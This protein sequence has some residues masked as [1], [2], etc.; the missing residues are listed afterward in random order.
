[1]IA[2]WGKR[3]SRL[4]TMSWDEVSTRARQ[5]INKRLEL[6]AYRTGRLPL[7]KS[8]RHPAEGRAKFFFSAG[9]LPEIADLLRQSS[10]VQVS[11]I[12]READ[13]ICAH[14][15]HL[16]GYDAL[17]YG[18][19]IDWH[20]DAVHGKRAPLKPWFKIEFLDFAEVGD[21]KVTW[22]LNRHQH[23][24]TLAKAWHFAD[25]ERREKYVREIVAQWDSWQRA[26]PYP[27]G[28]NWGSSLEVAFRS[29]SWIWVDQLL[30]N[31]DCLAAE[32]RAGLADGL[33]LNGRYVERYLSTY[34][35][36]NTHLLGEAV[37]LF[38]IGTLYPQIPSA[39]RWQKKGWQIVVE[40]A[41]RQVR[42]DGVY[43]EQA[44]YY[45]V[46]ALDFFLHLRR[47]ASLN[48]FESPA[49]FDGVLAKMGEVLMVLSQAGPP[50]GFGDDDG[51]RLFNPR[52]NRPEHLADPLALCALT[53]ERQDFLRAAPLTEEAVWLF[54]KRV[55]DLRTGPE[56]VHAELTTRAFADGGL[57]VMADGESGSQ[58]ILDAGP[59][60][61]GH[62][63]HGHADALSVNMSV[64][65]RP[66]LVDS[67]SYCYISND[68]Q[69]SAFR[70][71]AAH[72]TLRVDGL[73]QAVLDGPF[74]WKSIPM[75]RVERWIEGASFSLFVGSHDGYER[76]AAPVIHR[77]F[78][79]HLHG[80]FWLVR[81][82]ALGRGA[83]QLE[84]FWH[85]APQVMVSRVEGGFISG[86]EFSASE[87]GAGP[88]S[89]LALLAPTNQQWSAEANTGYV[90]HAY[91]SKQRAPLVRVSALSQLPAEAVALLV[92]LHAVETPGRFFELQDAAKNGIKGFQYD[93]GGIVQYLFFARAG[94]RWRV[95]PWSSNARILFCGLRDRRLE[96]LILCDGTYFEVNGHS[97]FEY[98]SGVDWLEGMD[99]DGEMR[100]N[101]SDENA[102]QA[103]SRSA[104]EVCGVQL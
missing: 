28:I 63:G 27:M 8:L 83:H 9:E 49:G 16:L 59:Q 55:L 52:R 32:F 43:F 26:N 100:V 76:M 101:S 5:E 92:P 40:E 23:L 86:V 70:G 10:S 38:F 44:L 99:R 46:Y 94:A 91:G 88:G 60:G 57:Y 41:K 66:W 78:V 34:F 37:A 7:R 29:L 35:S 2:R 71:T 6:A 67:G 36:P 104:A 13:E 39:E 53:F 47:L 14:R 12:L 85:F 97:V 77:R 98:P 84:T 62:A 58:M 93:R 64:D 21:H 19:E 1:M 95:G 33:A 96:K 24:V 45:H 69:R 18:A 51:G 102:V 74:S 103:F 80:G 30:A 15:F 56:T 72:N 87:N 25:E 89:R 48:G 22:E 61:I 65:G 81:D 54:G 50:I 82:L 20:L 73:D 11:E 42:A 90:S 17:D 79:F 3:L 4:A 68:D 75:T 31:C